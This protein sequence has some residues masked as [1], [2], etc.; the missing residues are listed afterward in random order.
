MLFGRETRKLFGVSE[1]REQVGG[2]TYLVS[3]TA[4][5][6]TNVRAAEVLVRD[7]LDALADTRFG[8]VLNLDA[9][10][11]L[12]AWPLA[13]QGRTV[14]A[15]EENR[16]ALA[17]AGSAMRLNGIQSRPAASSLP[18]SRRRCPASAAAWDAVMLDPP[19]QGCP[20]AVLDGVFRSLCPARI[21][22]VSCNPEAL[23]QDL[24][25]V[26][27]TGY[28]FARIQPVDMFPHTA[29]IE[30]VVVLDRNS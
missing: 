7:V 6:Q 4:L 2:V 21:V 23:V 30:T 20:P 8:R 22:Y 10:V 3:P 14:T 17:A 11:G 15:V 28:R 18:A 9:G 1:V 27:G 5:F 16:H 25:A 26:R 24:T 12:C 19:R 13:K 29:H